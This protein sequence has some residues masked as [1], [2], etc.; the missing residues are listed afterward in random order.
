MNQE[1]TLYGIYSASYQQRA[2]AGLKDQALLVLLDPVRDDDLD[3]RRGMSSSPVWRSEEE[4]CLGF[5]DVSKNNSLFLGRLE[6]KSRWPCLSRR[7]QSIFSAQGTGQTEAVCRRWIVYLS[8]E[9]G[10]SGSGGAVFF[11]VKGLFP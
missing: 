6:P 9:G 1:S 5:C 4:T 7:T 8:G 10:R 3:F 11:T 2:V